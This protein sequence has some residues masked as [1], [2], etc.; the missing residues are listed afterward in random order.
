MHKTMTVL[1]AL[2]LVAV[3]S[4]VQPAAAQNAPAPSQ[5]P[6]AT[7]ARGPANQAHQMIDLDAL[8]E[9]LGKDLGK[10]F[11]VSPVA[12]RML[13]VVDTNVRTAS[14]DSLR[15]LLR[16]NSL[17]AVSS[18]DQ[19]LILPDTLARSMP[20][21]IVQTD[22]E[23]V[24]DNEIVTRIVTLPENGRNSPETAAQL[25]P[26]LRPTMPLSAMLGAMS[27]TSKLVVVDYYDNVKRITAM[28]RELTN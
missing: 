18:G 25:V 26:I 15:A 10:E 13:A 28:I 3:L 7:D 21:R 8:L 14:F 17:F 20:T 9:R 23:D 6:P 27:G 11:I 16:A 5:T 22:D 24:S 4:L 12:P 2:L 1:S 19:I